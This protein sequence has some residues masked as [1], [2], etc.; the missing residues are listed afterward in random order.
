MPRQQLADTL[1]LLCRVEYRFGPCAEKVG[2]LFQY[3]VGNVNVPRQTSA[4]M[5]P[6]I[7]DSPSTPKKFSI[8]NA[9]SPRSEIPSTASG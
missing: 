3:S 8:Y 5:I 6:I 2:E 4:V 9:S 7:G 1:E